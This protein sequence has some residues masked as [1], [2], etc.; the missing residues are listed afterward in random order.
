MDEEAAPQ[1]A[2]VRALGAYAL[3][4]LRWGWGDAYRIW[5]DG[6]RRWWAAR[7]DRRG[8][9]ITADSPDELWTAVFADYTAR[10]VARDYA[11]PLADAQG[12]RPDAGA[13][14]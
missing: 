3:A 2:E 12:S 10:P 14:R 6:R 11:A 1:A 5:W 4:E 13:A 9:E 7:R 8:A